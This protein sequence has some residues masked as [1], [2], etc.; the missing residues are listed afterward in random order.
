MVRVFIALEL[1]EEI[2]DQLAAAQQVLRR[3]P[4]TS[5]IC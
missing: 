3:M 5:D 1:S 4:G 2:K